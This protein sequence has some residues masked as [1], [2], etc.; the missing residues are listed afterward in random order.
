M[1]GQWWRK[2]KGHFKGDTKMRK[3]ILA[4][5]EDASIQQALCN[6]FGDSVEVEY[7]RGDQPVLNLMSDIPPDVILA[8]IKL[9][10][11]G[12]LSTQ[13]KGDDRVAGVP[14]LLLAK[15]A[16]TV[17]DDQLV[18][19]GAVGVINHPV[20][21]DELKLR[22]GNFLDIYATADELHEISIDEFRLEDLDLD[23]EL[24]KLN[25]TQVS[26]SQ[27]PPVGQKE[28]DS[29]NDTYASE[30]KQILAEIDE[31]PVTEQKEGIEMKADEILETEHDE[32]DIQK[33]K[34]DKPH[35]EMEIASSTQSDAAVSPSSG[36][37]AIEQWIR[38]IAEEKI[39]QVIAKEDFGQIIESIARNV[40]PQI[41][42]E[43]VSKEI[44]RIK[45]K[46]M[47]E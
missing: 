29:D 44:E 32:M 17:P 35:I 37:G 1:G 15:E 10:K 25:Q 7:A 14:L 38:S 3:H 27:T 5:G 40:V 4:L 47:E 18:N 21:A 22:V 31:I 23:G 41:A 6:A 28:V 39:V 42:E 30:L 43:L 11:D 24:R 16:E 9:F 20:N 46:I 34:T 26:P 8:D 36:N 33:D 2:L 19:W 12:N 45:K 13:L